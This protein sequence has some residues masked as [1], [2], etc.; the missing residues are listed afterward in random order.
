MKLVSIVSSGKKVGSGHLGRTLKLVDYFKN[1]N[2]KLENIFITNNNDAKSTLVKKKIKHYKIDFGK[3]SKLLTK[4]EQI[5]PFFIIIDTY[6][7]KDEIKKKI[8][9]NFKNILVID[10]DLKNKH[11]CKYYLNY[12]LLKKEHLKKLKT[13]IVAEKYLIGHNFFPGNLISSHKKN[14]NRV[15]IFF[16]STDSFKITEKTLE[17]ISDKVFSNFK[18]FI[19]IGKHFKINKKKYSSDNFKF[20]STMN[21]IKFGNLLKKSKYAIGAGGVSLMERISY[22]LI[23]LVVITADNQLFGTNLLKE[24]K[25]IKYAGKANNINFKKYKKVLLNF[26]LSKN[27]KEIEDGL[28][29][30]KFK[31]GLKNI[32]NKV[33]I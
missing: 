19:I 8:Y 7:L 27:N 23:N 24:K 5:K 20:M 30:I 26:F 29:K 15:I 10:D 4:L 25:I 31:N 33:K 1:Q 17:I 18:F 2:K 28:N 16:G 32:Y 21:G 22:K 3:G 13:K 9:E 14:K 11:F 12:N 6:M